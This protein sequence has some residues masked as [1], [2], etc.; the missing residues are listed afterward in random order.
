[1]TR[2]VFYSKS[3]NRFPG[4]GAGESLTEPRSTYL[5]LYRIKDWRK[6]LSNFW[7]SVDKPLFYLDDKYWASLEHFF[8]YV[9]FRDTYPEF[10]MTF[11]F[12]SNSSWCKDPVLAKSAGKAGM[13]YKS[14]KVYDSFKK[15]GN[16]YRLPK[17]I[18][19]RKD[20]YDYESKKIIENLQLLAGFSKFSQNENLR[21]ALLATGN[22]QLW[23]Y[24]GF[25]SNDKVV[26][27]WWLE[28]VRD[29]LR[30]YENECPNIWFNS[31][32][33]DKYLPKFEN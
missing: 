30:L 7:T 4:E 11:E 10:A 1:M 13:I 19:I 5:E 29:C 28:K 33:V 6:M 21:L 15:Y 9:K 20:F 31:E 23:H 18:S 14:G 12:N 24:T 16:T 25:R 2:F 8:H 32:D 27:W 3:S 22:A 17:N 26:R